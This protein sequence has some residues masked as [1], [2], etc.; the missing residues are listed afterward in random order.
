M[1]RIFTED[2]LG[3]NGYVKFPAGMIRDFPR[4]TWE[5]IEQVI[6]KSLSDFTEVPPEIMHAHTYKERTSG[7]K[8]K[9]LIR[10]ETG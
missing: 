5:G 4:E 8:R 7:P 10:K 2:V 9:K 3:S 6:G 1:Q